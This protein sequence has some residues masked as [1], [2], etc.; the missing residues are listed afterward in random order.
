MCHEYPIFFLHSDFDR[1]EKEDK[2]LKGWRQ[3]YT[4]ADWCEQRMKYTTDQY[5][6]TRLLDIPLFYCEEMLIEP[7]DSKAWED[8]WEN[9]SVIGLEGKEIRL[10]IF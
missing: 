2:K 10:F 8:I 4:E 9:V 5:D 6:T 7:E 3:F 1:F